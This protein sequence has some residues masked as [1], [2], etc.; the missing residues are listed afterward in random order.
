MAAFVLMTSS[1]FTEH[2]SAL[3]KVHYPICERKD[4]TLC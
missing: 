4:V 3:Y 1:E 2:L